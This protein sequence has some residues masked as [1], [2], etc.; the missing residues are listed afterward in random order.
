MKLLL[1]LIFSL[2][3][4]GSDDALFCK[5]ILENN[6]TKKPHI[7]SLN[8]V[9]GSMFPHK[10]VFLEQL[11]SFD[12]G[13]IRK[14]GSN[15]IVLNM[16]EQWDKNQGENLTRNVEA[17][18]KIKNEISQNEFAIKILKIKTKEDCLEF[19]S[20]KQ[21]EYKKF[22]ELS[23]KLKKFL[24]FQQSFER[25][26]TQSFVKG[27][28]SLLKSRGWIIHDA[29]TFDVLN[30]INQTDVEQLVI[31]THATKNGAILD[32]FGNTIPSNIFSNTATTLRKLSIFSC[33]TDEVQNTYKIQN[34]IDKG[35][36]DYVYP[37]VQPRFRELFK[38]TTPLFGIKALA[39]FHKNLMYMPKRNLTKNCSL[40]FSKRTSKLAVYLN[41]QFLGMLDKKIDFYCDLLNSKNTVTFNLVNN[42]KPLFGNI[43]NQLPNKVLLETLEN[44]YQYNLKHFIRNNMYKSSKSFQ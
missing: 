25:L 17:Y 29:L 34:L 10:V 35:R 33:Y 44:K 8:I 32:F 21:N 9:R 16:I 24:P 39:K 20:Q 14:Q 42:Y 37:I 7:S 28:I 13:F 19:I 38:N 27:Q 43:K 5:E 18:K 22:L 23:D 30:R 11:R 3:A 6:N 15:H 12:D 36:F 26:E 41:N 40:H 2:N 1:M 31:I 4:F